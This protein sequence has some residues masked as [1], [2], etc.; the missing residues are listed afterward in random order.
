[1]WGYVGYWGYYICDVD[2]VDAV[3]GEEYGRYN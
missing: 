2:W 1:M 3:L